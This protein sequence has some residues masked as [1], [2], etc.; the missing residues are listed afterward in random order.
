MNWNSLI[1]LAGYF[2]A[3]G[4]LI[5]DTQLT[6]NRLRWYCVAPI[7]ALFW[8]AFLIVITIDW[9]YHKLKEVW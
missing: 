9:L 8:V 3:L 4:Y 7:F 5:K 6:N 1:Y 2:F